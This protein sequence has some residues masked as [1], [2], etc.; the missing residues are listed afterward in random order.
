MFK[1]FK[2]NPIK[3]MNF[4]N[5]QKGIINRYFREEGAWNKHLQASKNFII[6][7]SKDKE[8]NTVVILGSGWLLDVPL[9][10]LSEIFKKIYLV[11]IVHPKEIQHK[12]KKYGNQVQ[13]IKADITGGAIDEIYNYV[14]HFKKKKEKKDLK[15][16]KFKD[17][18]FLKNADYI[19]SLNLLNQ[20]DILIVDYLKQFNIYEE[21]E[22]LNFRKRIQE[23]H[24][25]ILSKNKSCL[26]TDFEELIYNKDGNLEKTNSLIFANLPKEK[27][28]ENWKWDFDKTQNY[29]HNKI[30]ILNVLAISF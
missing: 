4:I 8:K 24:L 7:A 23:H 5:D 2:K 15:N 28:I 22:I 27:F 21:I 30:T 19:V 17:L 10:E 26:I 3:I 25:Q 1:F 29:Y 20:L 6:K 9:Q 12:I 14:N 11:D 18:D 13:L 16:I